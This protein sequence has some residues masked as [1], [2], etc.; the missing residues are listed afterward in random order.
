MF[1]LFNW[2]DVNYH[3]WLGMYCF[4]RNGIFLHSLGFWSCQWTI[5]CVSSCSCY[6]VCKK[7]SSSHVYKWIYSNILK[8][9]LFQFCS[10]WLEEFIL[11]MILLLR[12]NM[13]C[14][15]LPIKTLFPGFLDNFVEILKC[16]IRWN[17]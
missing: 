2:G 16:I 4:C 15:Y 1:H 6:I 11:I 5:S 9:F 7:K 3:W 14:F 8:F 12:M 17:F 10:I 13:I